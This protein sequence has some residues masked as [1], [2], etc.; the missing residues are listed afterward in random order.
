M[1]ERTKL[2]FELFSQAVEAQPHNLEAWLAEHCEDATVRDRVRELIAHDRADDPSGFLHSPVRWEEKPDAIEVPE[3]V[4]RYR[5][6]KLIGSGGMALVYSA[7]QEKPRRTVA[8]KLIRPE[9]AA[10]SGLSRFEQEAEILGRLDHAGIARIYE[11]GVVRSEESTAWAGYPWLAMEYIGGDRLDRWAKQNSPTINERLELLAKI[12]DALHYAHQRGVLHRDVKPANILVT[13]DGQPKL[14]DFGIAQLIDGSAQGTELH[15]ATGRLL[16][17]LAYMSPE[18]IERPSDGLDTRADVYALGVVA[19]QLLT[20]LLPHDTTEQSLASA[21]RAIME[22]TPQRPSKLRP[23]LRGEIETVVLTA[24][25]KDRERRYQSMS[26]FAADLRRLTRS[27]PIAARPPST[28]YQLRCLARRNKAIV[29]IGMAGSIAVVLALIAVSIFAARVNRLNEQLDLRVRIAERETEQLR[30]VTAFL[31]RTMT[32]PDP[33]ADVAEAPE[34]TVGQL[35]Q[36]AEPWLAESFTESPL[37]EAAAR[38]IVGRSHKGLGDFEEAERQYRT[39]IM[40]LD[41]AGAEDIRPEDTIRRAGLLAEHAV[42]LMYLDRAEEAVQRVRDSQLVAAPLEQIPPRDNAAQLGNIGWVLREAGVLD[43]ARDHI[44]RSIAEAERAGSVADQNRAFS[45]AN[46][47]GLLTDAGEYAPAVE[48]Y[49]RARTLVLD[50][51]GKNHPCLSALQNNIG[52]LQLAMGNLAEAKQA[53]E[54]AAEDLDRT[55]GAN[56]A[57]TLTALNNLAYVMGEMGDLDGAAKVYERALAGTRTAFGEDHREYRSTLRNYAFL[58]W[59]AERYTEGAQTWLFLADQY[60][61]HETDSAG[62]A[63]M[64]EVYGRSLAVLADPSSDAIER[65]LLAFRAQ[66]ELMPAEDSM[67]QSGLRQVLTALEH[68]GR[69]DLAAQYRD[70]WEI[71]K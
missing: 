18:Q 61:K 62:L 10:P 38:A 28:L 7:E 59:D 9:N 54:I 64:Y 30:A 35:L 16:G 8:L 11:A 2:E 3:S 66:T 53:F 24:I 34:V 55:V 32:S 57:R 36:R 21:A 29:G 23:E 31:E 17:T 52:R 37:A 69:E 65:M 46:L 45:L 40:R 48:H 42:V 33:F 13:P 4:G 26:E 63:A 51:H 1:V 14:L 22:E 71:Q 68:A 41:Q 15:T 60:R 19:Y 70:R 20:G 67:L 44:E 12:A 56:H 47:A 58:L 50:L 49:E 6:L 25:A 43:E 5:L 27:Q 39:A